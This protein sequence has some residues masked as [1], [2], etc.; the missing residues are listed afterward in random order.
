[1]R[2]LV[3]LLI[4]PVK[5]SLAQI[6]GQV[7]DLRTGKPVANAEVF[8]DNTQ[9]HSFSDARGYF[10]L[11][12]ELA[13]TLTVGCYK[14]GFRTATQRVTLRKSEHMMLFRLEK[15]KG[16]KRN[17]PELVRN[18]LTQM[19]G[20]PGVVPSWN[21]LLRSADINLTMEE[22]AS[23]NVLS[24]TV[25]WLNEAL[26]YQ[27]KCHL[28]ESK[29][30]TPVFATQFYPV[31]GSESEHHTWEENRF[32]SYQFTVNNFLE[33]LLLNTT[34]Q[35]RYSVYNE[36]DLPINLENQVVM[37]AAGE[38]NQLLLNQR[39][40]IKHT[41]GESTFTSWLASS[42]KIL[43]S[44]E[45]LILNR[46]SVQVGG[47]FARQ[48]MAMKLPDDYTPA[49]ERKTVKLKEYFEKPYVH[50]D[51]PYYYP[52]DTVWFKVYMNYQTPFLIESL[53]K[54]V[55]AELISPNNG[56]KILLDKVLKIDDGMAWGEFVVP[57][58][59]TTPYVALR[60]YTNWQRN[61]S[62]PQVFFA[63]L[64]L[65]KRSMNLMNERSEI[66]SD[67]QVKLKFDKSTYG[68]RDPIQ[69]TIDIRNDKNIRVSA[70]LSVSVTDL[71]MVRLRNDSIS[72]KSMYPIQP[73]EESNRILFP[74]E[75]GIGISGQYLDSK[76]RPS[77]ATI[78][79]L[80]ANF[81]QGF[82][83]KTD[84][85]GRFSIAGLD[86][87]DVASVTYAAKDDQQLLEGGSIVLEEKKFLPIDFVWPQ[88]LTDVEHADFKIDK[89]TTLLN[90][91]IV[92]NKRIIEEDARK[93]TQSER[94][95]QYLRPFGEPDYIFKPDQLN[96]AAVNVI[97]MLR[98]RV[99]GLTIMTIG[100]EY[101][102]RFVRAQS[103]SLNPDPVVFIDDIPMGGSPSQS[104]STVIPDNVASIE[105]VS[106]LSP[107]LGSI[108]GS[109]AIAV[110]T[111]TGGLRGRPEQKMPLSTFLVRGY[112]V[113]AEFK[114]INYEK[115]FRPD[116][117][118]FR[119]TL[120]WNPNV[121]LT[122]PY[123]SFPLAFYASD[124][125][126]PYL[127]AIEGITSEDKLI[128]VEHVFRLTER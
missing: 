40:T 103:L 59:L 113:P 81:H 51:R 61:F 11:E 127:I 72:I 50:T 5:L 120:Y 36:N 48:S 73:M 26:G 121:V 107:L 124:S 115:E 2:F 66:R 65:I 98:G 106:R 109:G 47:D 12:G 33:T 53:S 10:V 85:T 27:L 99:P 100:N 75:R 37:G 45:G 20:N 119:P 77:V 104:L 110:Y 15:S 117:S 35:D 92:R 101:A 64:P 89:N 24:G 14:K 42:G 74:L 38:A 94:E 69:F 43:F 95:E 78:S 62:N 57:D 79:L 52:G 71:S 123:E 96:Q 32:L 44:D 56:G 58:T 116:D 68:P 126:G 17:D 91:I 86:F 18:L 84:I 128:R 122:A 21:T 63:F 31:A 82:E 16:K 6:S 54:V 88:P 108:G 112:S 105:I 28:V 9:I 87:N 7:T 70:W 118:D 125:T 67:D 22:R 25:H 4:F 41:V 97:E 39:I 49:L 90:E 30:D 23:G 83:F 111:K 93:K 76:S 55:Y 29:S 19:T 34:G 80:S 46:D 102:V 8:I 1:M 3:I 60:A 13:G 114:G